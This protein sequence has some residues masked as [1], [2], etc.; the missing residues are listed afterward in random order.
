VCARKY[1]NN[2]WW[3]VQRVNYAIVKMYKAGASNEKMAKRYNDLIP[4]R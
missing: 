1:R 2:S 4:D 3:K